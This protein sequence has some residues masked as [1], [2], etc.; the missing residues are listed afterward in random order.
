MSA[1]VNPALEDLPSAQSR[2]LME[3]ER[4]DVISPRIY[5]SRN[6]LVVSGRKPWANMDVSLQP[7]T[8]PER[9]EYWGIEVVGTVP[10]IG[11]P[12]IVPY[13]VELE[14]AGCT[15]TAGIDVI[16]ADRTERIELGTSEDTPQ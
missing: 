5:P 11:Q 15:G 13:A 7:L 16:G 2:Q 6:V 4:A 10:V 9:P 1:E 3:F 8:Y 14:V 12:A